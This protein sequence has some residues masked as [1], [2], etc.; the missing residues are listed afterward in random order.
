MK[1]NA[2]N[3]LYLLFL[4]LLFAV[5]PDT[6][7]SA[8]NPQ[9]GIPLA[10]MN[11]DASGLKEQVKSEFLHAWNGYKT[12]ALGMDA[13]KPISKTGHNWY[14]QSLLM[15][16]VDAYDVMMI[17]G[18]KTE[19]KEAKEMILNDLHFD[20]DMDVQNFEVSIRILAGL[21][22]AYELDG[23][24]RFLNLADDLG[25][26]LIKSFN[27]PTGMPYRYVNLKTGK[28]RGEVSNPAEIGT[29][30]VEYGILSRHTGDTSY[31]NTAKR[32]M[33]ALYNRRSALGLV[34]EAINVETGVWTNRESHISG[35]IDSYLE[36]LLKAS[37]LFNDKDL[38]EM[39]NTSIAAVNKYQADE[40]FGGLWYGHCQMDSGLITGTY[41][42]ALDAF[43]AATLAMNGDLD[44]AKALQESNYK[45]WMLHGIEPEAMNY[46]TMEVSYPTYILRPENIESAYYLYHYTRDN[47]YLRM[48]KVMFESLMKYCKNETAYCALKNVVTKEKSDSMESFFFAETLKYFFLLFD[49]GQSLDFD[50]VIFNTEAHPYRKFAK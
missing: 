45:M 5:S 43:F 3:L 37:I 17:M 20:V 8:Q 6:T 11:P 1:K 48:G 39:W 12:Y 32:A 41:Y 46:K 47:K 44:R 28:T 15:T 24:K 35:S 34:G 29:Y 40:R 18:L 10:A 21:I 26:R 14:K 30:I 7:I 2:V 50:S 27:S 16:P 13:L 33:V 23:D 31:Y 42:G 36:Y 38:R 22:S 25:K 19:A 9:S 4:F 49:D